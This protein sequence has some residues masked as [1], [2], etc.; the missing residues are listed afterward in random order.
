MNET[1]NQKRARHQSFLKRELHDLKCG[2]SHDVWAQKDISIGGEVLATIDPVV[3]IANDD[4]SFYVQTFTTRDEV[5]KFISEI[6]QAAD[7]AWGEKPLVKTYAGGKPNYCT[8]EVTPEVTQEVPCKT[9]PDAPHGFDRNASHS[10]DRYVCE[11]E[12]WEPVDWEAVAADQAMTIA[13]MKIE[14]KKEWVG[15]SDEQIYE[16]RWWD[17]ETAF[18]VNKELKKKNIAPYAKNDTSDRVLHKEW[19]GLTDAD[20]ELLLANLYES[21]EDLI[22]ATEVKLKDKNGW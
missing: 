21:V 16:H 2:C 10:A 1:E 17:E 3:R 11:C 19:V 20:K 9:H 4:D 6:R 18:A 14:N 8:P 5:E 15:L 22:T 7:E 13:M 12:G